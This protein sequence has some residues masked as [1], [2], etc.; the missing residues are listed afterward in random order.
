MN[1]KK[2]ITLNFTNIINLLISSD[3]KTFYQNNIITENNYKYLYIRMSKILS[4]KENNGKIR[5]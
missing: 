3:Y 1:Y 4:A 5:G 2:K